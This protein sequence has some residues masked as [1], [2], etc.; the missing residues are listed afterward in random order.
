MK[1]ILSITILFLVIA[2]ASSASI[3][4]C[5]DS[6]F[7]NTCKAKLYSCTNNPECSYQLHENTKHI[8]LNADSET[9]PTLYFSNAIARELYDCLKKECKLP[10]IDESYPKT[11][12]FDY[13]L[14]EVY[15][16]CGGDIEAI[17]RNPK[18]VSKEADCY[19]KYCNFPQ[20]ATQ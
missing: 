2:T 6:A 16:T 14:I 4:Q 5:I 1:Y 8:F 19:R 17:Y 7:N 20:V 10:E 13:C 12:P 9:F 18:I 15:D 11:L 3:Y